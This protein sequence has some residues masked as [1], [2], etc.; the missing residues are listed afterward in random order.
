MALFAWDSLLPMRLTVLVLPE[1]RKWIQHINIKYFTWATFPIFP[2]RFLSLFDTR[3]TVQKSLVHMQIIFRNTEITFSVNEWNLSLLFYLS[4]FTTLNFHKIAPL[5]SIR[6]CFRGSCIYSDR[7]QCVW[8]TTFW[9]TSS[10]ETL[11]F[12]NAL[13]V[14]EVCYLKLGSILTRKFFFFWETFRARKLQMHVK[15]QG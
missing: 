9:E 10:T 3:C 15:K 4:S 1:H 7:E 12:N 6:K 11:L 5:S 14:I 8:K 13:S 2:F